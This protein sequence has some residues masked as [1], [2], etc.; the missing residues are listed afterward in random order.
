MYWFVTFDFRAVGPDQR[1]PGGYDPAMSSMVS[2]PITVLP[3][4]ITQLPHHP[5]WLCVAAV[6]LLASFRALRWIWSQRMRPPLALGL[7]ATLLA[8]VVHQFLLAGALASLLL[9][10]QLISWNQLFLPPGR[11]LLTVVLAWLLFWIAFGLATLDHSMGAAR[12]LASLGYQLLRVPDVIGVVVRPWV[13]A[14]PHLGAALLVLLLAAVY[15]MAR[16]AESLTNERAVL[17]L[18]LVLLLAASMS[19]PPRQETRYV[20]N[21]YPLAIVIAVTAIAHAADRLIR[22]PNIAVAATTAVA[23][24]GFVMSEDFQLRHLLHIDTPAETFRVGMTPGVQSHLI[25]REDYRSLGR[26]LQDNVP[27]GAM[28]INGVHGLDRYYSGIKYFYVDERSQNFPDWACHRGTVER[29]GNYPMV[30]TVDALGGTREAGRKGVPR[31]FAYD[32]LG[33]MLRDLDRLHPRTLLLQ[34]EI[35]VVELRG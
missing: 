25:I 32:D 8:A 29:W 9:L 16:S 3:M 27:A 13:W 24:G 11:A 26:W 15:R 4:P 34:G 5:F 20:F 23:L 35:T 12:A 7:L 18:F 1:W 22:R 30:Y 17:V 31:F 33:P 6:L 28:V 2:D 19:H 10:L 14:V 21:L